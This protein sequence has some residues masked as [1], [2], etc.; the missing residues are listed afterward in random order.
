MPVT[1]T[2]TLG[3]DDDI[4]NPA[5]HGGLAVENIIL[6]LAGHDVLYGGTDAV[7]ADRLVGGEGD[8]SLYGGGALGDILEGGNGNDILYS[9]PGDDHAYGGAGNDLYRTHR[10]PLFHENEIGDYVFD[11]TTIFFVHETPGQDSNDVLELQHFW[12]SQNMAVNYNDFSLEIANADALGGGQIIV[13]LDNYTVDANGQLQTG[14]DFLKVEDYLTGL[15]LT[16]DLR[17]GGFPPD[18]HYLFIGTAAAQTLTGNDQ[19]NVIDGRA[20][21]DTIEGR[22]GADLITGGDGNDTIYGDYIALPFFGDNGDRIYGGNGQDTVYGGS[23]NDSIY[24]QRDIDWLHG[25]DGNDLVDGGSGNDTLWGDDG[26]DTLY[27]RSGVDYLFGG[28]GDDYINGGSDNGALYGGDGNDSIAGGT[29]MD[30]MYGG[31]GNDNL[32]GYAGNDQLLGDNGDDRLY[33]GDDNDLL[34]GGY[35]IDRLYGEGGADTFRFD[36]SAFLGRDRIGDFSVAQGDRIELIDILEGFN[37]LTSA[38][39]DFVKILENATDSYLYVDSDGRGAAEGF[40]SVARLDAVLGLTDEAALFAAGR[41]V[42][43]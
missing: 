16:Y 35:G 22:N 25:G 5:L 28:A 15:T 27:G 33:G 13:L 20:G 18:D 9:S 42:V 14:V 30:W 1:I 41:I 23:D 36:S 6:G 7:G 2:G 3:N 40:V 12:N 29:A 31:A 11:W 39:T 17:L 10:F 32:R 24:G 26:N 8:D 37:P 4:T 43:A 21:D 19:G 38:I 34:W